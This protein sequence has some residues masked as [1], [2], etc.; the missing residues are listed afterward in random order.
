MS[1]TCAEVRHVKPVV[2][3][4]VNLP[5]A[6]AEW[7]EDEARRRR[8]TVSELIREALEDAK[9]RAEGERRDG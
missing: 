1:V 9:R 4:T 2:P 3:R 5:V 8:C 6:M 7:L